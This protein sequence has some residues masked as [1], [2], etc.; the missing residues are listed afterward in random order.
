MKNI[1]LVSIIIIISLTA[2][3]FTSCGSKS[4]PANNNAATTNGG[5]ETVASTPETAASTPETEPKKVY[6]FK[7]DSVDPATSVATVG[8]ERFINNVHKASGGRIEITPFYG[9]TLGSF[10]DNYDNLLLGVSDIAW[11]NAPLYAG[12]MPVYEGASCPMLGVTNAVAASNMLW[13]MYETSPELQ[14]DFKNVKVIALHS[15]GLYTF[16]SAKKPI[17]PDSFK[18][19]KVR[20]S[21]IMPNLFTTALGATPMTTNS[22]EVYEAVQKG[23]VDMLSWDWTGLTNYALYEQIKYGCNLGYSF[24]PQYFLMNLNSYNS[25]PDDLK[26]VI[27]DCSGAELCHSIGVDWEERSMESMQKCID[28]GVEIINVTDDVIKLWKEAAEKVQEQWI[29]KMND[30]GYD[31][32]KIINDYKRLAAKWN[33]KYPTWSVK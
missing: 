17:A 27:D 33:E 32:A 20:V 18:G 30:A 23:L 8:L 5:S 16:C 28:N 26:K 10:M 24:G 29:E 4:T 11:S 22:N 12:R 31:G 9:A 21:G 6:K 15:T 14:S 13:E 7:L 3:L 1:R 2:M 25:L 19:S